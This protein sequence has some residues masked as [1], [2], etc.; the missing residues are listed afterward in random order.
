GPDLFIGVTVA[1]L[2]EMVPRQRFA[3][4]PY[5][6]YADHAAALTAPNGSSTHAVHVDNTGW[7]GIGTTNPQAQLQISTTTGSALQVDAGAQHLTV[8]A[9]DIYVQGDAD[10]PDMML[11]LQGGGTAQRGEYLFGVDGQRRASVYYDK[12]TNK[13]GMV[14][15]NTQ[16]NL[17]DNGWVETFANLGVNGEIH[18]TSNLWLQGNL[19]MGPR[20]GRKPVKIVRITH[21]PENVGKV[22]SEVPAADYE[23]TIGS[24]STGLYDINENGNGRNKVWTFVEGGWWWVGVEFSSHNKHDTPSIDVVCFLKG[25]VEYDTTHGAREDLG[26]SAGKSETNPMNNL[27]KRLLLWLLLLSLLLP[28]HAQAMPTAQSTGSTDT[29]TDMR[30]S[31]GRAITAGGLST[32]GD[33]AQA[34]NQLSL[35]PKAQPPALLARQDYQKVYDQ[36]NALLTTGETFRQTELQLPP[37]CKTV[38]ECRLNYEDFNNGELFFSFCANYDSIDARGYCAGDNPVSWPRPSEQIR[39]QLVRAR[40]MYGFLALAEPADMTVLVNGVPT[41]VRAIGRTGVLSATREIANI[42]MIFGN[43]F[44]VDAL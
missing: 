9:N 31:D 2:D 29:D 14:N 40:E 15:G 4:A 39:G 19:T 36:A 44:M 24:W 7:V 22:Y 30:G 27:S 18:S 6:M 37:A 3:S 10:N 33:F 16:L 8:N 32:I 12:S 23:C 43:E 28:A 41:P 17:Y 25:M 1:P 38:D 35:L 11:D 5:A 13:A 26:N 20:P 42:H 21:L 34:G